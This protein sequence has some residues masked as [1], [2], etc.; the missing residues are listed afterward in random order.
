[1]AGSFDCVQLGSGKVSCGR[2][3]VLIYVLLLL[4]MLRYNTAGKVMWV[5]F[6]SVMICCD[7]AGRVALVEVRSRYVPLRQVR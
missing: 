7:M 2:F 5:L 4:V 3:A 6:C 1:M